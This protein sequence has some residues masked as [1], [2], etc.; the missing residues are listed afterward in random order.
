MTLIARASA[1]ALTLSILLTARIA[2]ARADLCATAKAL[3]KREK[4]AASLTSADWIALAEAFR[5]CKDERNRNKIPY[6]SETEHISAQIANHYHDAFEAEQKEVKRLIQI[7]AERREERDEALSGLKTAQERVAELEARSPPGP[8]APPPDP[9][10]QRFAL[11]IETGFS[12][13]RLTRVGYQGK[14]SHSGGFLQLSL[15]PRFP[16]QNG[17]HAALFGPYYSFWRANVKPKTAD[18]TL[19]DARVHS[20]GAK[21]EFDLGLWQSLERWLTVHPSIEMGLDYVRFDTNVAHP[22]DGYL[23]PSYLDIP[24]F[25]FAGNLNLCVW[26]AVGCVGVRLKSVPGQVSVPTTQVTFGFDPMRLVAAL[27]S[28]RSR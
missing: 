7:A 6:D 28:R 16:L 3:G 5:A 26:D 19:D 27:K 12:T 18:G 4:D 21:L 11:R 23:D 24:G 17:R 1:A 15:L 22:P 10:Y 13:G 2:P 14:Y 20:F 8:P 9:W 25:V